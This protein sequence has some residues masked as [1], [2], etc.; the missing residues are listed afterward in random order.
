MS[1]T[2]TKIINIRKTGVF[3]VITLILIAA[4]YIGMFFI[5]KW[6]KNEV[7][8]ID[9]ARIVLVSKQ[10]MR[11]A[12]Y[13]YR[14][15]EICRFPVA[16]GLNYGNKENIGDMKTPEG[17]FGIESIENSTD[18]KHDFKDGKGKIE[19]VYGPY[20]IR[21]SVPGHKGIGIHG[22]HDPASMEKRTT[23]GCI[24]LKNE[25]LLQLVPMI[26]CGMIVVI[27]PSTDDIKQ[28]I[29]DNI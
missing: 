20:F 26:R 8:Q 6:Y 22:T 7:K 11:L 3:T 24:R 1:N 12:V 17:V 21:L 14:G 19:G 25:D 4:P 27:T 23:E 18:W 13:D 16:C 28:L 2:L 10:D 5:H 15:K 9:N 29:S